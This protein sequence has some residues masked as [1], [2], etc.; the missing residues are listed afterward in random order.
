MSDTGGLLVNLLDKKPEN[1][2]VNGFGQ[3]IIANHQ[4]SSS[5]PIPPPKNN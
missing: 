5:I 4:V 1:H 3:K 2:M